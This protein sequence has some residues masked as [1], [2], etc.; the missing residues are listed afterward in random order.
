MPT[1]LSFVEKVFAILFFVERCI[2][3]ELHDRVAEWSM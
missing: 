3:L 2:A 1:N